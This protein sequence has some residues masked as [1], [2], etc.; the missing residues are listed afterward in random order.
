ME[1]QSLSENSR[2]LRSS[3]PA[4]ETPL[5]K[6]SGL[7]K[8]FGQFTAL[9]NVN[10][11]LADGE[12]LIV[13]GPSG[14]GKS[15]LIRCINHLESPDHGE[16][17]LQGQRIGE[18]PG[19]LVIL[20]RR[21][22]MVFQQFNLFPHLSVLNNITVA[23][24]KLL[25]MDKEAAE[26]KAMALLAR[27]RLSDQS[28]KL[29]AQLSGGQQQRVAIARALAMDP[30][31]MLFDEPTSALDPEMIR[32]VLD[33]MRELGEQG[34]SMIVV[35]HEMQFARQAA[36]RIAFMDDGHVL[37]IETPEEFFDNH[38]QPRLQQFLDNVLRH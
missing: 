2:A 11:S 13:C 6:V 37:A 28:S 29:P 18:A 19:D 38:S 26:Q 24:R 21:V 15:T 16:I 27:V 8:R 3:L 25:N 20:R 5:L 10:L 32:E 31:L 23:P 9:H 12:R 4:N 22:G 1:K 33:V 35:T 30:V 36:D 7:T 14:S 34:M 17:E